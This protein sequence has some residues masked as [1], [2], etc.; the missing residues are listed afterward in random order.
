M[1]ITQKVQ[2]TIVA[3]EQIVEL[4]WKRNEVAITL[5]DEKYG[6]FLYRIAYNILHDRLDC[7]ECQNDT[8]HGIWNSIPPN[9]PDVFSIFISKIMRNIAGMKFRER[10][11]KKNIPSE[12]M[13]CMNDLQ[14]TLH[15]EDSPD[16]QYFAK[17]LGAHINNYLGGLT[18]RQQYIFI[19][20]FYIGDKLEVIADKLN[21]NI[22]TVHREIEKIKQS[23]KIYLERNGVYV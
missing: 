16:T 1:A 13:V 20:R 3:D 21:V 10:T 6:Q 2:K 7:E 23:L 19:G 12:M 14:D 17:E 11:R 22:S 5:T 9:R 18:D 8:Y 15:S 4:Y